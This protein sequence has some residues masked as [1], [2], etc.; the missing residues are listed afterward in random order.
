M[1]PKKSKAGLAAPT[2]AEADALIDQIHAMENDLRALFSARRAMGR[3]QKAGPRRVK[4][5]AF[6]IDE[7]GQLSA[8]LRRMKGRLARFRS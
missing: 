3:A 6:R 1:A 8:D 5:S 2:K 7:I 4:D